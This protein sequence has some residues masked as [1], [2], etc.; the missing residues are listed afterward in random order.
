MNHEAFAQR[1]SESL[2]TMPV[3]L[4]AAARYILDH[5]GDVALLTMREQARRAGLQPATMTRFAQ[6][7]GLKGY[8][9][10]RAIHAER[11]RAGG[12]L[13]FSGK[14]GDQVRT[15]KLRGGRA[16]AA[17]MAN[18]LARQIAQL[19]EP[20]SLDRLADAAECLHAARRIYCLGLRSC[21]AVA[22]HIHYILSLFTGRTVLLDDSAGTGL[23]A[24]RSATSRDVLVVVSVK[25][26]ARATIE[27]ARYAAAQGVPVLAL[28]DS[29]ASPLVTIARQSLFI[30]TRSPSFFHSMTPAF[31]L[32]EILATLAAGRGG[33]G[34]AQALRHTEEQLAAFDVHWKT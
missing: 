1:V 27:A 6:R 11:I 10:V 5:P 14:A 24:I 33:S 16:L 9:A 12:S 20:E 18:E 3:Q 8:E 4:Q 29:K 34:V 25:P 15:Q 17:E 7:M 32:G 19:A 22:R 21:H 28:T 23:D 31:A 13:G 2:E 26:Y 30:G